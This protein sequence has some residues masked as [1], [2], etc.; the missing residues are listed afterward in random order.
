MPSFSNGTLM[1]VVPVPADFV[2]VPPASTWIFPVPVLSEKVW[3]TFESRVAPGPISI[4][5]PSWR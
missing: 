5:A 3:S 4:V 1:V 2:S